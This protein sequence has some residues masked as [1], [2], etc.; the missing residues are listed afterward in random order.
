M[1]FLPSHKLGHADSLSRI[2]PRFCESLEDTVIAALRAESEIKNMLFNTKWDLIIIL[3]D[4]KIKAK[5]NFYLRIKR[6]NVRR[7]L[8]EKE[9]EKRW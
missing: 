7:N 4:V 8:H 3:A 9:S 6:K 2:I 5:K 1:E